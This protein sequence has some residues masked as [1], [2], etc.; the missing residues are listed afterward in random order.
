MQRSKLIEILEQYPMLDSK[1]ALRKLELKYPYAE[2]DENIGGGKSD[3]GN[4]EES[5]QANL[6][7]MMDEDEELLRLQLWKKG[8]QRAL[9]KCKPLDESERDSTRELVN[10]LYF[11]NKKFTITWI[12]K[13]KLIPLSESS[14]RE[15]DRRF[16]NI[17]DNLL[18]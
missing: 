11:D 2:S 12:S 15:R 4:T 9:E 17:L 7:D 8:V 5:K 16:L 1:I 6:I 13:H 18:S 14:L 10:L 3:N